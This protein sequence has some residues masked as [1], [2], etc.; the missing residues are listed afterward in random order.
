MGKRCNLLIIRMLRKEG[1]F[2]QFD[3]LA[4]GEGGE[5]LV[6]RSQIEASSFDFAPRLAKTNLYEINL[7]KKRR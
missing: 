3:V 4:L 5:T 1:V 6:R 7:R 2:R